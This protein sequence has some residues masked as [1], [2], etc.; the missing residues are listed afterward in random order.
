MPV[1]PRLKSAGGQNGGHLFP[2]LAPRA[3]QV[4]LHPLGGAGKGGFAVHTVDSD[5]KKVGLANELSHKAVLRVTVNL[6]R[7]ADLLDMAG[8]HHHDAV[9]HGQR[10]FLI[11]G[12]EDKGDA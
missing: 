7:G 9:R 4:H 12:H 10:L 6:A 3:W 1:G 11:V 5:G 2:R 8:S